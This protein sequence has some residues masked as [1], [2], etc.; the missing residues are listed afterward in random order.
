MTEH[1]ETAN[2]E[3]HPRVN[4]E[5]GPGAVV[6]I[7]AEHVH[8]SPT[9][10]HQGEDPATTYEHGV[11][12]LANG[13]RDQARDSLAKALATYSD[14][15][16]VWFHWLLAQ[17]SNRSPREL[18]PQQ[19]HEIQELAHREFPW[20]EDE[21]QRAIQV[22]CRLVASQ[23]DATTESAA[24]LD[25]LK[26]QLPTQYSQ[27]IHHLRHIVTGK[28]KDDVWRV[29][30]DE[31]HQERFSGNRAGRM[32]AYFA[33]TPAQPRVR[34]P[35]DSTVTESD[36]RQ[37]VAVS[38]L[39]VIALGYLGWLALTHADPVP[40]VA[41][42]TAITAGVVAARNG[43]EWR[44]QV[45]RSATRTR[46]YNQLRRQRPDESN[47]F[48]WQVYAS[49]ECYFGKYRPSGTD[50]QEWLRETAGIREYLYREIIEIYRES[51]TREEKIRWL[52]RFLACQVRDNGVTEKLQ[53]IQRE[54]SVAPATKI[55]CRAA[56]II[57]V[58]AAIAA[59]A[60]LLQQAPVVCVATMLVLV[61]S[62]RSGMTRWWHIISER[63]RIQEEERTCSQELAWR[64]T[65]Y[66]R[67]KQKLARLCP[68]EAEMQSWLDCDK[69][70]FLEETLQHYGLKWHE[71]IAHTFLLT[72]QN[73]YRKRAR[74]ADGPWRYSD[75]EMRLFL[76]SPDGVREAATHHVFDHSK[77]RGRERHHFRFDAVS[78]I[79]VEEGDDDTYQLELTLMNGDPR[80]ISVV[81][82]VANEPGVDAELPPDRF[83]QMNLEMTG[84]AHTLHILEGIAAEGK[85]W[86]ARDSIARS[87]SDPPTE[88]LP[89][90]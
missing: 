30:R 32:W 43:L 18:T 42:P 16:E 72:P 21:W 68:S 73:K 7:Q 8:N 12:F 66:E 34:S 35:A 82:T 51:R 9:H 87:A 33:A 56:L 71:I 47:K 58:A 78:S 64:E 84:F 48:A 59:P 13:W 25:T 53:R 45:T 22:V 88:P 31:A 67:W 15:A 5:N 85:D 36:R 3:S 6:G 61:T 70:V 55:R 23:R 14:D 11:Q 74:R 50:R 75:Y 1:D 89:M 60:V 39:F 44:Y 19:H 38:A 27:I 77:Y 90:R 46:P 65:E 49:F 63:R 83:P 80:P 26:H 10:V 69:T 62:G 86:I 57:L 24:N 28:L 52:I 41:Y 40:L 20:P 29:L 79:Y 17:L 81:D 4:N 76:I 2:S 37:A 54:H